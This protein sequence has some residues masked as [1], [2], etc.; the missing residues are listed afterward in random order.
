MFLTVSLTGLKAKTPESSIESVNSSLNLKTSSKDKDIIKSVIIHRV[1]FELSDPII[2]LNSDEKMM[3]SFDDLEDQVKSY[4]Y[5]ILHCNSNWE[6]SELMS[7]EYIDGFSTDQISEYEFSLNTTTPFIHYQLIFPTEYLQLTKSGN[8]IIQV[9]EDGNEEDIVLERKFKVVDSKLKIEALIKPPL[10][11]KFKKDKQEIGFTISLNN[12]YIP[13]PEMLLNVVI[14]QNHRDDNAIINIKPVRNQGNTLDYNYNN[15]SIFYGGNEFR[16]LNI[17]SL[18]YK[19]ERVN[20]I[21]YLRDGYHVYLFEDLPR[22]T[23]N[24]ISEDD[25]NGNFLIKTEDESNSSTEGNYCQVHFRLKANSQIMNSDIYL[26]GK[27]TNGMD[28]DDKKMHYDATS[29]T[30]N[31]TLILKQGYYDYKYFIKDKD[32]NLSQLMTEGS[33]Y[34]AR[35]EYSIFV[36][37]REPGTIYDQLIGFEKII[38]PSN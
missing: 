7:S 35:N 38:G 31:N 5:R 25:L 4:Y 9:F 19:T 3:L 13:N 17:K 16:A 11:I 2:H 27:L 26:L 18:K 30:F 21:E 10:S 36:Y 24:Y 29:N 37:Y 8:Y 12:L 23:G 22:N 15:K 33:H 28:E 34:E 1:G 6:L 20:A 32:G 14:E